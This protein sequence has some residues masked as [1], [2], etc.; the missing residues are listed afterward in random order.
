M[1]LIKCP[2]CGKEV[3]N[4][5]AACIH[6]GFPLSEGAGDGYFKIILT[7]YPKEQKINLIKGLRIVLKLGLA[8]A[9]NV[10]ESLPYEIACGLTENECEELKRRLEPYYASVNIVADKASNEHSDFFK[11]L[12]F[13]RKRPVSEQPRCPMCGSVHFSTVEASSSIFRVFIGR[14]KIV[15]ICQSCG[16]KFKPGAAYHK[17]T[18]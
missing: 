11:A 5:A 8:D 3:S 10:S 13:G 4:R 16:H 14:G 15:N 17:F 18:T 1:A 7:D 2:E 6:C 9:K 12:E